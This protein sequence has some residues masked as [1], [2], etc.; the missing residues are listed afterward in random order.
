MHQAYVDIKPNCRF[1]G[2]RL[3]DSDCAAATD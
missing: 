2:D 1:A 3:K